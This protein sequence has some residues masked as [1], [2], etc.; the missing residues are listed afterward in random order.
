MAVPYAKVIVN[1]VAGGF[2]VRNE[3]PRIMRQLCDVGLSFDHEFTE[4]I[5]HAIKIA[6][7]AIDAGYQYLIAVGGDG[8]VNEVANGILCSTN[9]DNTILGIV[10]AGTACSFA[11][12]LS[13]AQDYVGACSLLTGQGRALIDVG[14]VQCWSQGRPLKRFF[15]NVADAGF[16]ATIVDAWK[17]LPNH[18]GQNI[19]YT[20][21]TVEGF[22]SIFTHQN[23]WIRLRV[24][25][26]VETI[27]GCAVVVANGQYMGNR[28]QIAPH[29]ML[30]DGLLDVVTVGDVGKT[31]ILK[32][33]PT[34]YSGS[35]I[36]HPKIREQKATTV[37]I[38][39][40]KQL[41]VE[42]DGDILGE[43][44]ASFRVVP[45]A[46]TIVV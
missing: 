40:D 35:H 13:I 9:S 14:I 30:D 37:T 16:G 39:S 10:S 19:Y 38:E 1:P 2:S 23:K 18:F 33:W 36:K 43:S 28:M 8:T 34:L 20:L 4:G 41:L 29:A 44:P 17:H 22:R 11:R 26:E 15:V 21:R 5:G 31:E 32:I 6:G 25:N 42:A 12:S 46:L 24:G 7:R 3:W 27:Y 45:S